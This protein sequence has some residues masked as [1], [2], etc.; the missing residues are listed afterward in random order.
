MSAEYD[1]AARRREY[2]EKRD[3]FVTS[4]SPQDRQLSFSAVPSPL[5][6]YLTSGKVIAGYVA[7]GSEADPSAL[8][9]EAYSRGCT[10]A[11]P[12]VTSRAS[13]MRFLRWSPDIALEPGPF[14][15]Q[16]PPADAEPCRPD[17]LLVPLVAFDSALMRLGQG[18]GHYDRALS[19]L[20]NAIAIGL[21]WSIQEAPAIEADPWDIPMDAI[22]TEKAWI[23][24]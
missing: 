4:L 3:A 12:R 2:R 16:Q 6:A 19:L 8:L 21:A 13:P 10:V 24:K 20:D 9:I 7:Q 23:T 14:G 22:L 11:L 1:K 17:L 15:L 5:A 18:A